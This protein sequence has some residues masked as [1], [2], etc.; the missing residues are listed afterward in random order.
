M[1][2]LN[3]TGQAIAKDEIWPKLVQLW[4]L[5][6]DRKSVWDKIPSNKREA[7]VE[8]AS[9]NDPIM[10][11]AFDIYKKLHNQFFGTKFGEFE[12]IET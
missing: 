7:W 5:M 3:L 10:D 6:Q 4:G 1:A 8:N 12:G 11:I 9:T 2:T